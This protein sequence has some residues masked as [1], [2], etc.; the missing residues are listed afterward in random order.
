M[1]SPLL[2]V[3]NLKTYF[4][5]ED[6]LVKA[7]DGVSFSLEKGEILGIVGESGSGKSITALTIMGLVQIPPGEIH[8][9][10]IL[11]KGRNILALR[12]SEMRKLRGNEIGMVFQ[13]P[14]TALN[15]VYTI[16]NQIAEAVMLHSDVDRKTAMK[17]AVEMLERV[18]IPMAKD[19]FKR[20]PHELSGGMR[21]RAMIAMALCC[22]PELLICDEPTTAL[23]VTVQ[24]QILKLID[25]LRKETGMS[26]IMITHDLAVV[27]E[28][29]ERVIVMY[30]GKVLEEGP[31]SV[32]FD[33]PL[34]PYTEALM[35][36][37]PVL[38]QKKERLYS[39]RGM[40]PSP[41]NR[42]PGCLFEPRCDCSMKECSQA[43]PADVIIGNRRVKCI[44][45]CDSKDG[46]RP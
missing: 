34:H 29:A 40:V 42:P 15:P 16:G 35:K 7:V 46:N 21:Q 19:V 45:Y 28:I 10:E 1:G 14:M 26:V 36:S 8:G 31:S 5:T 41:Y 37:K 3:K 9:G 6:G 23:D 27:S 33:H 43:E 13:E 2:E 38:G 18:Q 32:I 44:K 30:A 20:Y 25:S 24:A 4:R 22:N 39:I 17:R 11:F 12:K